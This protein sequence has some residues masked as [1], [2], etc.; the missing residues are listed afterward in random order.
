[1]DTTK[2]LLGPEATDDDARQ[3]LACMQ[4]HGLTARDIA[5][6]TWSWLRTGEGDPP[7]QLGARVSSTMALMEAF[8]EAGDTGRQALLDTA[9]RLRR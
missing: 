3:M 9:R 7:R 2:R 8:G 6:A 4:Q 5:P 1:M